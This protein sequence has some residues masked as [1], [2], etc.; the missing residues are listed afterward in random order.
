MTSRRIAAPRAVSTG[1]NLVTLGLVAFAVVFSPFTLPAALVT[2][3]VVLGRLEPRGR[4]ISRIAVASIAI[5]LVSVELLPLWH[6]LLPWLVPAIPEGWNAV[7]AH[8]VGLF[9][10]YFD[11][12]TFSPWVIVSLWLT[13]PFGIPVGM[14]LGAGLVRWAE[15]SAADAEWHPLVRRKELVRRLDVSLASIW[16]T[17]NHDAQKQCSAPPLGVVIEGDLQGWTEGPYLVAPPSARALGMLVAGAS[18]SGKTVTL[19]RKVAIDAAAGRQVIFV[20]CKGT[21]PELR[22]RIEAA[23]LSARPYAGVFEWPDQPLNAWLG[24]GQ[25]VSNRLMQMQDYSEPYYEALSKGLI[26]YAVE[27][28]DIDGRGPCRSSADFLARLN[29]DYLR[30]AYEGTP[31][32]DIIASLLRKPET[33]D[34]VRMRYA[35]FFASL[36]GAFDG[37]CSFHD[38]DLVMLR[39][40]T[41]AMPSDAEAAIRMMLVDYGHYATVRKPRTDADSTLI[42]DEFSAVASAAPLV[43]NLAERLRDVGCQTLVSVQ[44]WEGLGADDDKRR[45]LQAALAGGTILHRVASPEEFLKP[46]GTDRVLEGSEQV[47]AGGVGEQGSLRMA[48]HMKISPDEVRQADVG[49]A[50][51]IRGGKHLRF[52]VIRNQDKP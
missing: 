32:A 26:R 37:R 49:E 21:D 19:E 33:L 50:W 28:P 35:S 42:I 20:D 5:N 45:R 2:A 24:D 13:A 3:Y 27:A 11:L 10:F 18:G 25:E 1:A 9:R 30:R 46:S 8:E 39:V 15:Y 31:D 41:L 22:A 12:V 7:L 16:H 29:A 51:L 17:Y 44:S 23:Y 14:L 36:G 52:N 47:N 38:F 48:H 34:G 4:D 43:T 40:P 6:Y